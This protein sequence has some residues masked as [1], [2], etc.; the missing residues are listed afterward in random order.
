MFGPSPSP[1]HPPRPPPENNASHSDI[2]DDD[3]SEVEDAEISMYGVSPMSLPQVRRSKVLAARAAYKAE[4]EKYRQEKQNRR[5]AREKLRN[6]E[7][8]VFLLI[9]LLWLT[10]ITAM[11]MQ[12]VQPDSQLLH[13]RLLVPLG[14]ETE[15]KSLS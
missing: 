15:F 10:C 1:S 7:G 14:L 13:L 4:K 5:M 8:S 2:S 3:N 11:L 12:Q 6:P 9:L